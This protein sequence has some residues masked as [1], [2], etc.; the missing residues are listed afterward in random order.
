VSGRPDYHP[1]R[2]TCTDDELNAYFDESDD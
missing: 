1:P 2:E